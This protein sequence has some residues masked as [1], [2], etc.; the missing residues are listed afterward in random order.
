M[1]QGETTNPRSP[2]LQP[3]VEVELLMLAVLL[4]VLNLLVTCVV[5][6]ILM[7]W[8]FVTAVIYGYFSLMTLIAIVCYCTVALCLRHWASVVYIVFRQ[9]R[10]RRWSRHRQGL[11][12]SHQVA[13]QCRSLST[14]FVWSSWSHWCQKS[15]WIISGLS[16]EIFPGQ[17][18]FY[19][20]H[21]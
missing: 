18:A 12:F 11:T 21:L 5:Q 3:A 14:P 17:F 8:R 19:A 7:N 9:L 20:I 1:L 10:L 6:V 13:V 15:A 2:G 4:F 16:Q